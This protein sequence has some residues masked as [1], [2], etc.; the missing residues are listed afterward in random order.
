MVEQFRKSR[1][2]YM[3]TFG[4]KNEPH[5]RPMTNFNEDPY[6]KM[7]FPTFT[8]TRKVD[9]LKLDSKT[10]IVFPDEDGERFYEVEGHST[11]ASKQVVDEKWVWWYLYWHPEQ[12]NRFWFSPSTM[13]PERCIIEVHPVS[14][15][16]LSLDNVDYIHDTYRTVIPRELENP[17]P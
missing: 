13:H 6:E 12:E 11:F 5:S 2:V 10:L 4:R 1:L 3:V 15:K 16:T 8:D 17:G 7:W 14:V 9:D